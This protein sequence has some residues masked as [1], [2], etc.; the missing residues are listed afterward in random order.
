[1]GDQI[2]KADLQKAR[3][4]SWDKSTSITPQEIEY[5]IMHPLYLPASDEDYAKW[6]AEMDAAM[7][8]G[9]LGRSIAWSDG[10]RDD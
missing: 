10:N 6:K 2:T 5:M 4:M 9:E 1:M 8:A 3:D 7:K